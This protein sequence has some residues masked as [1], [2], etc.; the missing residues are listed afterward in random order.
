MLDIRSSIE[1]KKQ[2]EDLL[3]GK[4][5]AFPPHFELQFQLE[6]VCFNMSWDE[7][8][9]ELE[10]QSD[11]KRQQAIIDFHKEMYL[12]VMDRFHWAALPAPGGGEID[13]AKGITSM[14]KAVKDKALVFSFS[15]YGVFWMPTGSDMMDFVVRLFERP[16]EMHEIARKKCE[17][18]KE[19]AKIQKESGADFI[20]QNTDFGFN[21]GPFISPRHFDEFCRPYMTEIIEYMHEI[22]LKVILHSDGNLKDILDQIASTGVDGYQSVDPQGGMD[23]KKVRQ[24]YPDWLLMGNVACNMLQDVNEELIRDSVR[25]CMQH[26]GFGKRYIFS[27]SNCIFNSMPLESYELMLDEYY[28]ICREKLS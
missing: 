4:T 22:D 13:Y 17:K 5:A 25:Y 27:T 6:K 20:V 23:I 19:L 14:K 3:S 10:G 1:G 26:G 21:S 8:M 28:N 24:E 18:A 11:S 12:K 16:E 9:K 15:T 7:L 2:L